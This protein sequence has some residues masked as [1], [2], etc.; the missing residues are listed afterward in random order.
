M[1]SSSTWCGSRC[2]ASSAPS[3]QT[4]GCSSE[5][6]SWRDRC[7]RRVSG[8]R[9]IP[10]RRAAEGPPR[11]LGGVDLH[12]FLPGRS[13]ARLPV[14]VSER[15]Q[16][17]RLRR[18]A[19]PVGARCDRRAV[20]HLPSPWPPRVAA[21]AGRCGPDRGGGSRHAG[22]RIGFGAGTDDSIDNDDVDLD[23]EDDKGRG[24]QAA[25][26]L[27]CACTAA[28]FALPATDDHARGLPPVPAFRLLRVRHAGGAGVG[29]PRV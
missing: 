21:V 11:T 28:P 15:P 26:R 8:R 17:L 13:S 29:Q 2:G 7:R 6:A 14:A 4:R 19:S 24:R 3:H 10:V 23:F 9:F 27:G 22:L 16:H 25:V 12:L 5:R 18:L 20:R 1:P